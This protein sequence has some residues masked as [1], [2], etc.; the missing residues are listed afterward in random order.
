MSHSSDM[1]ARGRIGGLVRAARYPA[2]ELTEKARD[3]FRSSFEQQADPEGVLEPHERAR[4]ADLLRRAHMARIARL[5]AVARRKKAAP[6]PGRFAE[7]AREGGHGSVHP[8]D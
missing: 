8:T 3:T 1:A 5:S 4:R 6:A 2:Q 7:A